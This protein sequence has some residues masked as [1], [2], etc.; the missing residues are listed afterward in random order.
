MGVQNRSLGYLC[1]LFLMSL[2]C[3]RQTSD[4]TKIGVNFSSPKM[5]AQDLAGYKPS[6]VIVNVHGGDLPG[7]VYKKWESPCQKDHSI[8]ES[9]CPNTPPSIEVEVPN[10]AGRLVQVLVV[11]ESETEQMAFR[12]GDGRV[13]LGGGSKSVDIPVTLIGASTGKEARLAGRYLDTGGA[14]HTGRLVYRFQP[15]G[16]GRPMMIVENHEFMYAGWAEFFA[17]DGIDF[18]ATLEPQNIHLGTFRLDSATGAIM[19]NG[20]ILPPTPGRMKIQ[21]PAHYQDHGGGFYELR[22][23][24]DYFLSFFGPGVTAAHQVGFSSGGGAIT[25]ISQNSDGT[26]DIYWYPYPSG[27]PIPMCGPTEVC[28]MGGGLPSPSPGAIPYDD[29][30]AFDETQMSNGSDKVLGFRGPFKAFNDGSSKTFVSISGGAGSA[31]VTWQTIPHVYEGTNPI[32]GVAVFFKATSGSM[33]NHHDVHCDRVMAEGYGLVGETSASSLNFNPGAATQGMV[34]ICPIKNNVPGRY[35]GRA[36]MNGFGGGGGGGGGGP[37]AQIGFRGLM[38]ANEMACADVD[39]I[40]LDSSH[41]EADSSSNT[42]GVTVNLST[43][44][45]ATFLSSCGSGSIASVFIPS[46]QNRVRIGV[47]ADATAQTETLSASSVTPLLPAESGGAG[48]FS[49][50]PSGAPVQM[51]FADG[52]GAM[53]QG[54]QLNTC[55]DIRLNFYNSSHVAAATAISISQSF[56]LTGG[57]GVTF[58]SDAGCTASISAISVSPV[59]T[60]SPTF[61][62]K[63]TVQSSTNLQA[64]KASYSHGGSSYA[65]GANYLVSVAALGVP[66]Y[67]AF[68]TPALTQNLCAEYTITAKDVAGTPVAMT[69]NTSVNRTSR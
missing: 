28:R 7:P 55:E 54:L 51:D 8:D 41:S 3:T 17:I 60:F 42:S 61:Y 23:A 12:Y 40:L 48:V 24:R 65:L 49:T 69:A 38:V 68:N 59:S 52:G 22:G 56:N 66:V 9:L 4:T 5:G 10:G 19:M 31:T 45:G 26:G 47:A 15:P 11:F 18:H 58:Y 16:E 21:V 13:D 63:G 64:L 25:G 37:M 14:Y 32:D 53:F 6:M 29:Y 2:A 50:A 20:S 62:V 46:G 33:M 57:T 44:G 67:F 27:S 35:L 36:M 34:A 43:D 30:F 1:V 39:V